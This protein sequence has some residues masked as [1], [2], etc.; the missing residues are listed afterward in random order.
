VDV[1]ALETA[2]NA[3][4]VRELIRAQ[5]SYSQA[6]GKVG[7]EPQQTFSGAIGGISK[8]RGS[9]LE[10]GILSE[11]QVRVLDTINAVVGVTYGSML[12]FGA[13]SVVVNAET[14]MQ[15]AAAVAETA[16]TLSIPFVGAAIVVAAVAAVAGMYIGLE[17]ASAMASPAP[18]PVQEAASIES[19]GISTGVDRRRL[20]EQFYR[21][22]S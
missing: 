1:P 14:A 4:P 3:E 10:L 2:A 22:V 16:E 19:T 18:P 9:L 15:L 6:A 17:A 21:S 7:F 5:A 13:L 12:V 8:V 20:K 11:E